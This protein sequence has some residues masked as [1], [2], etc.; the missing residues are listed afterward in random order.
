MA[1]SPEA[2]AN[3]FLERAHAAKRKLTPMQLQKLVY[4]AHGWNLAIRD[5]PLTNEAVEAWQWGPVYPSLYDALKRYGSGP[6]DDQI[7][8]NNWALD[9][10]IRGPVI[11]DF[12]TGDEE[13][14]LNKV[15]EQYGDLQ[16]FQL[17][18]LTHDKDTPWSEC[19]D[20]TRH[21]RIPDE[22]IRKHFLELAS[23][24]AD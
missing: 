11:V 20:G 13:A 12:F 24:R 14:V 8:R 10:K 2:V 22:T 7:H 21:K 1:H 23:Q 9:D 19:Y 3:E 4:I 5:E 6:I 18:A 17:S 15:W 16:A